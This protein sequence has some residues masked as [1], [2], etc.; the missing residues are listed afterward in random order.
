MLAEA[1]NLTIRS[2]ATAASHKG[3][4]DFDAHLLE[5]TT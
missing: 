4:C 1:G 3:G 2:I 5:E